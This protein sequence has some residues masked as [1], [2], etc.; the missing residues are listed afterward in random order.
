MSF[1]NWK[2]ILGYVFLAALLAALFYYYSGLALVAPGV[3]SL[4]FLA[5]SAA[6]IAETVSVFW[7]WKE[8][9]VQKLESALGLVGH[10]PH[11]GYCLCLWLAALYVGFFGIFL[12]PGLTMHKILEFLLSWWGLSFLNVIFFEIMTLLWFKKIEG[13]FSL[14]NL[15]KGRS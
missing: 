7:L 4:F 6:V 15:Y 13:E 10:I 8:E 12:F 1:S 9:R 2:D 11:C 14:R 5:A 3:F